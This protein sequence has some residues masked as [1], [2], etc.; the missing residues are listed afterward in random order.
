MK[1]KGQ[2]YKRLQPDQEN[3]RELAFAEQWEWE[4]DN[5][6]ILNNL[7][8]ADATKKERLVAATVIQWL[9]S[10]VGMSFIVETMRRE[11]KV[12]EYLSV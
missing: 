12:R 6:H 1:H 8:G 11:P 3:A 5:N 2:Y 4:N 9:G 7:L 10:A